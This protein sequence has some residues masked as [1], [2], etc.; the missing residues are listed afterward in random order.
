M[1]TEIVKCPKRMDCHYKLTPGSSNETSI[2]LSMQVM[3]TICPSINQGETQTIKF[4]LHKEDFIKALCFIIT[5]MPLYTTNSGG[6]N[7]I[8]YTTEFFESELNRINNFFT[9]DIEDYVVSLYYR[10]DGRIYLKDLTYRRFNIRRFLI[11]E[12]TSMHFIV[13]NKIDL[14]LQYTET[15]VEDNYFISERLAVRDNILKDYIYK[16]VYLFNKADGLKSIEPFINEISENIQII[17][18]DC[19]KLTGMFISTTL[20]DLASRNSYGE[21]PRWFETPFELKGKTVYLS[22][23]WYGNGEYALMFSDFIKMVEV[24]YG[25][26][27]RCSKNE[28]GEF[29]LWEISNNPPDVSE[30]LIKS[31]N[32][33][34]AFKAYM[35]YRTSLGIRSK[36]NYMTILE[37]GS[38]SELCSR[39]LGERIDSLYEVQDVK[40]LQMVMD[41]H[42]FKEFDLRAHSQYSSAIKHY[43]TFLLENK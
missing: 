26:R 39:I 43:I 5:K 37:R 40:K 13:G 29:E 42:E 4:R 2:N 8:E 32:I 11:E 27:F 19:F 3:R 36:K 31:S 38:I 20:R 9:S 12:K 17:K 30:Q 1:Y 18:S 35:D 24:C 33:E 7:K 15:P 22:T 34:E 10:T 23:Q 6:S 14:R 25:D 28:M 21:K 16:T 41:N